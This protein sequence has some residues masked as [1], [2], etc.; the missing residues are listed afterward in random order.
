M[1]EDTR[2]WVA[3][4]E[5]LMRLQGK[6]VSEDTM[7]REFSLHGRDKRVL[8]QHQMDGEAQGDIDNNDADMRRAQERSVLRRRFRDIHNQLLKA[9]R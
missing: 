9:G 3:Q 1:S 8:I 6:D 4:T 5:S 7:V 2:D